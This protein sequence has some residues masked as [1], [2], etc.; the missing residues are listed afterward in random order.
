MTAAKEQI[1][2]L[3]SDVLATLE[4]GVPIELLAE[5]SNVARHLSKEIAENSRRTR[6]LHRAAVDLEQAVRGMMRGEPDA[7]EHLFRRARGI[8]NFLDRADAASD[9]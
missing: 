8:S 1:D 2:R 7:P 3:V 5:L 4:H 9:H 6:L